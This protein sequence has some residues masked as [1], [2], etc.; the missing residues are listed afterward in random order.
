MQSGKAPLIKKGKSDDLPRPESEIGLSGGGTAQARR[1]IPAPSAY[2]GSEGGRRGRR[3]SS[4]G[5][6]IW[7]KR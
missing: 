4:R 6:F 5:T 3:R 2:R 7:K 1:K